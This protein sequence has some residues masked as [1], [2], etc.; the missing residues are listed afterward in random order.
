M[1]TTIKYKKVTIDHDIYIKTFTDVI[2]SYL[3]VS[4]DDVFNTINNEISFPE[5]TT[6]L[7]KTLR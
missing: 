3:T 4:T 6:V 1:V 2:L 5:L 7:K